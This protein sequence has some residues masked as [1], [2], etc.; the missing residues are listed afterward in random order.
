MAAEVTMERCD[1]CGTCIAVC[2]TNALMLL[3]ETLVVN[4]GK[5]TGCGICVAVCPFG[6]LT[7]KRPATGQNGTDHG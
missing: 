6:A 1:R 2:P 7:I 3:T 5:C 4:A